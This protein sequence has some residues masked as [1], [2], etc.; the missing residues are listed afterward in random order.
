MGAVVESVFAQILDHGLIDDTVAQFEQILLAIEER[1]L[2]PFEGF[3]K[4]LADIFPLS[5][6]LIGLGKP[7]EQSIDSSRNQFVLLS[8][9]EQFKSVL[10]ERFLAALQEG[11]ATDLQ[12]GRH[13]DPL[14]VGLQAGLTAVAAQHPGGFR[15]TLG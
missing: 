2:L 10:D 4:S 5:R 15:V 7:D 13:A 8:L 6:T 3:G 14:D 12:T 9:V 11:Q 1:A